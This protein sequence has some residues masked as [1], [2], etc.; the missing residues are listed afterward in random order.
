MKK[1][2]TRIIF[3]SLAVFLF[4][5]GQV[6]SY[7]NEQGYPSTRPPSQEK[8][9]DEG[10]GGDDEGGGTPQTPTPPKDDD[11]PG[12]PPP[13]PDDPT[14]PT[15]PS[16][17]SPG[18]TEEEKAKEEA[19]KIENEI[20]ALNGNDEGIKGAENPEEEKEA[21]KKTADDLLNQ[22]DHKEAEKKNAAKDN[23]KK[24][25]DIQNGANSQKSGDPVRLTDGCYEQD[26]IDL[27]IGVNPRV[28]IK[29]KYNSQNIIS[30]SFGYGWTTNLD[31]RIILG[32]DANV[33]ELKE[34]YRLCAKELSSQIS[35]LKSRLETSYNVTNIS[36]AKTELENR[37]QKCRGNLAK[38]EIISQELDALIQKSDK[39]SEDLITKLLQMKTETEEKKFTIIIKVEKLQDAY[40]SIDYDLLLI[41]NLQAKQKYAAQKQKEYQ[42]FSENYEARRQ[43]NSKVLFDGMGTE[44]FENG[45]DTINLIDEE[46]YPHLFYQSEGEDN[47]WKNEKDKRYLKCESHGDKFILY[48]ADGTV[49]EF[50]ESGFIVKITD[51]PGN[52][53][54]I[55][56]NSDEKIEYIESSSNEH[57]RFDYENGR[58]KKI[59][60]LRDVLQKVTYEYQNNKLVAVTDSDG[61]KVCMEYNNENFLER[62]KKDDGSF[63]SFEY[64]ERDFKGRALTTKTINEENQSERFE[65]YKNQNRTDYIDHDGNRFSYWYD[66]S[67]RTI[68]ETHPDGTII[69]R[70]YNE[71]NTLKICNENGNQII[72]DYD[73]RGNK[74]KATYSDAS[75]ES[76]QYDKYN[77]VTGFRDRDGVVYKYNRD[78][79]GNLLSQSHGGNIVF[80]QTVDDRGL[81]LSRTVN[82][83]HE[84]TT[85]YEYDDYGNLISEITDSLK[86]EYDYDGRNRLIKKSIGG[87]IVSEYKYEKG[88][89]TRLDYNGLKT[90]CFTNCRKDLVILQITDIHTGVIQKIRIEYDRRHLP[91][92]LYEG[93]ENTEKLTASYFYTAEGKVCAELLHGEESWVKLY[94]YENTSLKEI[95]Q[96]KTNM[97][98]SAADIVQLQRSL[99]ADEKKIFAQKINYQVLGQNKKQLSI[100]SGND[101]AVLFEFDA[102]GNLIKSTDSNNIVIQKNYTKAGRLLKEQSEFGGWYEYGY[103]AAGLMNRAGESG[104][105][106]AGA[107]YYPDGSLKSLTDRYGSNTLYHYDKRGRVISVQKSN[108]KIWYEYDDFNR[109]TK[110]IVGDS[111]DFHSAVYYAD[112][113][114]SEDDRSVSVTEGGKYKIT[115]MLD[116]FGNVLSQLKGN[117]QQAFVY[118]YQN[119]LIEAYDGYNNKTE[120]QYNAL[121]KISRIILPDG[122]VTEY[123]YNQSGMLEFVRDD[124]GIAYEA[125]YDDAGRLA[126]ERNRGD[127]L[128]SYEYDKG[129]RLLKRISGGD[130][131]ESYSYGTDNKITVTDGRAEQYLYEYDSF[132]RLKKETN[133]KGF[134]QEY[135]YDSEGVLKNKTCFDGESVSINYL[136]GRTVEKI[137]YSDGL[138]NQF[139]YDAVGNIVEAS[140]Q[141]G[142]TFYKYDQGGKLIY[143]KDKES[144]EEIYFNYDEAGNRIRLNS[145]NR[146]TVYSYGKNNEVKEIF[147]SKQRFSIKLDYDINGR[148][149]LRRFGNGIRQKTHYDKSGRIIVRSQLTGDGTLLWGEGYVYGSDGKRTSTIDNS[150]R[151]TFY[152][153]NKKGQLSSVY[154]PFTSNLSSE[155]AESRFLTATERAEF[156]PLLNLMQKGLA[157]NLSNLQ[158]LIKVKYEYDANGNLSAKLTGSEKIEYNYDKENC[159]VSS[160]SYGQAAVNYTYDKNGNLLTEEGEKRSVKYAY[161]SQ[162]RLIYCEVTDESEKTYLQTS[163]S[164]DA[165]GR[166]SI[167]QDLDDTAIR[168]IYD[169]LTFDIIKQSPVL[170]NGLFTDSAD[171]GI[172]WGKTG[173]PTGDRYRYLSEESAVEESRYVTLQA[174]SYKTIKKRYRGERLTLNVNG[175]LAAQ[176]TA[177]GPQY[178]ATDILGSVTAMTDNQGVQK[179]SY[180]YDA[181]GSPVQGSFSGALDYGY[182]G[183]QYDPT[184]SLYNYGYRDYNPIISRFTTTDPIRDGHNWF[185]YCNGDPVNFIDPNGL[186]YYNA[187][188]QQSITTVKKTTVVILRNHDGLGNDFDSTRLIYKNNGI[189][190]ELV[191]VDT[192]GA[193]CKNE[194]YVPG[195]D[196]TTPD[197]KYYLSNKS[198][199]TT[200]L[201]LQEDG[202]TNSKTYNN[203]LSLRTEDNNLT[204]EQRYL[205]NKG[206]IFFHANQKDKH[207]IYT[208]N[209]TP[210][211]AACIIGQDG[212]KHQDEM[213]KYLMDGVQNPESI[214][215]Y[216]RSM[217]NIGGC[218]K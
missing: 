104:A 158:N 110:L 53:I 136:Q 125:E 155:S 45:F 79:K 41:E 206:D 172:R 218:A 126:W 138:E 161:N 55:R 83:E 111:R 117:N 61:D 21:A 195:K 16:S 113:K 141:Y 215:V 84:V 8:P 139:V 157:Y 173:R 202:I 193:N 12:S 17:G 58:I 67:F 28:E 90:E 50:N 187:N 48:E 109:I 86:T 182:L 93:D 185:A 78:E 47:V 73:N 97:D 207:D 44:Y 181:F 198:T 200:P 25:D 81:V 175:T 88:K 209:E 15:T 144:G 129:S 115:Y 107:A 112:Y 43:R 87:K 196:E 137:L 152:E 6:Y 20:K 33:T 60:N 189:N 192:V 37:I 140:N 64:D 135:F 5:H 205:I 54:S 156:V 19:E 101:A 190:T 105:V 151:V 66:E 11:D 204:Q 131:I 174:D 216:I 130:P 188:G 70:S 162:N 52:V 4:L 46:G 213:M 56:R 171:T 179:I 199:A 177:D 35:E 142:T 99:P 168:T 26:E 14:P 143:Q 92:R 108:Q 167:V 9:D 59:T 27:S 127:V 163:Y 72:Y 7:E 71:D 40:N 62:L 91:L 134:S 13:D 38:L 75:W 2:I 132:G 191:Y 146:E 51:R 186:F 42:K 128:K 211:S 118:D 89:I 149:V 119:N 133:R 148:E 31:E 180:S 77:F 10:D 82:G 34:L 102:N 169:G 147:D 183:K 68:K 159:L 212:Q 30:S 36:T 3:V 160:G 49:K 120:Y 63:V 154:Y 203:V 39:L 164:Y 94:N 184:A 103:S 145:L 201:Y 65:Y 100:S 166:R 18:K 23:N 123:K 214:T 1:K 208:N 210:E 114:Y 95:K 124:S 178:F 170:T 217:S 22:T 197:G 98:L 57:I 116:A 121:G 29:R 194:N 76:W 153:Y 32:T 74:I 122:A 165:F 80:T 96:F 85:T 69:T 106:S 176:S 150:G 24:I